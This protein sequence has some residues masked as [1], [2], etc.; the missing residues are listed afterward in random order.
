MD[1]RGHDTMTSKRNLYSLAVLLL[2]LCGSACPF[3]R[4]TR[5]KGAT[6]L[7][8]ILVSIIIEMMYIA[9]EN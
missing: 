4:Q 9:I 7:P 8:D 5:G 2:I 6:L 3:L 1:G